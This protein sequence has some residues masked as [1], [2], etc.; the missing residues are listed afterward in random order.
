MR[1]LILSDIHANLEAL[2]A[3]LDAASDF[4]ALWNLGD[5]VGYGASPNQVIDLI[6]PKSQLTVRGNHD[7]V[8]CGLTSALGFNPVARAAAHWTHN[9]LTPANLS[10]L[11]DLP[12]GPLKPEQ[13]EVTCA[14]GSPLNEDQYILN[15]RD[16][17]AP[18]QQMGTSITF[19]GHTHI[20]GGFSQKG[21]D[22]HE[23][24]PQLP[25]IN[26]ASSWTMPIPPG[27]RH[28]INPGSVGQ[29]RDCDWRA[30]FAIYDS[31]AEIIIFHRVPYDITA[32]QGRI[33]MAGLP[34]RLAAR[35]TEGR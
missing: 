28:L 16:A 12:Q 18:L 13:A 35:L 6:R 30:A 3:V 7:R 9:Q 2:N 26:E 24:R 14:H 20:Q 4:D 19:F 32:S 23:L 21:H 5:V 34:E 27:T 15:M 29:P 25:R 33:L 31:E 10:W 22:W 17:W 8:C 11:K 1:A